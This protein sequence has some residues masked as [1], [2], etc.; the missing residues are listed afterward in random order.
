MRVCFWGTRG[1]IAKAG[2]ST[3]RYGGN[4]SCVEIQADDGTLVVLDCG[5]GAHGLG[6]T[7]MADSKQPIRGHLL[8]SHTHWDHI[9]GL[10]FFGPLFDPANE[11]DIYAPRGLGQSLQDTLAG[12]MQYTYFPVT[13]ED[14]GAT[15]HYHDLV[16]GVFEVGG[17]SVRTQYLNHPALALGYRLEADGA[18]VV[19]A[20]DHEPH[21]RQLAVGE[22]EIGA[23][24]RRHMEFL[25]GWGHST[26]KYA[27]DMCR[28]ADVKRLA[29][30]HHD[31]LRDDDD[32]DQV[33][34]TARADN[35]STGHSLEIFG[36]AEGTIIELRSEIAS[37]P[38]RPADEPSAIAPVTSAIQVHTILLGIGDTET[39]DLIIG[40]VEPESIRI[41]QAS[42]HPMAIEEYRS[43][44]PSLV[45]IDESLSG[46][47]AQET[48]NAIRQVDGDADEVPIIVVAE[49][50]SGLTDGPPAVT[51][52]LIKPF[53]RE[54]VRTRIMAWVRRQSCRCVPAPLPDDEQQRL[55]ALHDLAILD[56]EP[57]ERFDRITR[58]AAAIFDVPV[59]LITFIDRDRQW[60]KSTQGV[61]TRET[62]RDR[63]FCAH[64]ILKDGVTV[65]P[66]ALLDDRFADSPFVVGEA[67]IRFYA[68]HPLTANDGSHLGTLC[69]IDTQPRQ[70]DD[71][72]VDLLR[73]LTALV[74][75]ELERPAGA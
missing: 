71:G 61:E 49:E 22:G 59:V 64:T 60:F 11:W 56:T 26:T 9:Q 51:D 18:S 41:V 73:D 38:K 30:S 75:R 57:E 34:E 65:I 19:Y 17:I 2:P 54:Y 4:T 44:R 32:V 62:P 12:Q 39:A 13:L 35:R 31:P 25:R 42:N 24:D 50:G 52:W 58:L 1:S 45:I 20:C 27:A 72:K 37:E 6:E 29:L 8:I 55:A 15:I 33:V 66:D 40:A 3:V 10:P 28:L 21:S 53:S 23:Q 43:E 7:L 5:T 69:L 68:G 70:L 47:S 74:Q 63:A 67:R 46:G 36:A 16:E 14:L 48:S